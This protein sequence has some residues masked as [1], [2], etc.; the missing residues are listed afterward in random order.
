[1]WKIVFME[2]LWLFSL[3]VDNVKARSLLYL[4]V[5]GKLYKINVIFHGIYK[6]Y[7]LTQK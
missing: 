1:M 5:G 3:W 2:P 7:I 6:L 4:G